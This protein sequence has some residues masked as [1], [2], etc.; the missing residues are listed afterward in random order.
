MRNFI[1]IALLTLPATSWAG[2]LDLDYYHPSPTKAFMWS[3]VAP[4]G[5]MFY[6][7]SQRPRG[8]AEYIEQGLLFLIVESSV[9]LLLYTQAKNGKN[10]VAPLTVFM[11]IKIFEFDTVIDAAETERHKMMMMAD[12]LEK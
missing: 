3:A 9:L 4:A 2:K 8:D 12:L 1:L 6:L 10:I 11:G 7:V 5:G